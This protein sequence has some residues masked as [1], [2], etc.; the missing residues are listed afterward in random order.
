M[1]VQAI[2]SPGRVLRAALFASFLPVL[3]AASRADAPSSDDMYLNDLRGPWI[4]Q[5]TLGGKPVRYD[6]VGQRI[7]GGAWLKLHMVQAGKGPGYQADVFLGYDPKARD[8]IVHWLDRFGAAGA[9][10]VATG[11][12][13]GEKLI[14]S[15]PYAEGAFRDTFQRDKARNTWTLLLESQGKD[16]AWSTFADYTLTRPK[17]K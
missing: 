15:F 16:G 6:A 17:D 5:G 13:D 10:V 8:F 1:R 3:I 11:H 14:F 2:I 9:R 7:L 12:R 4:M